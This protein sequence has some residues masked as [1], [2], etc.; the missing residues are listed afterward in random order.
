MLSLKSYEL[1]LAAAAMDP[2]GRAE[3]TIQD[4]GGAP[5]WG[6]DIQSIPNGEAAQ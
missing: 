1:A 2:R 3:I 6:E 5:R 4:N